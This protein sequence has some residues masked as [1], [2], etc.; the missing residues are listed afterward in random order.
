MYVAKDGIYR[1]GGIQNI[2]PSP[3]VDHARYRDDGGGNETTT[4]AAAAADDV[5]GVVIHDASAWRAES[6][7]RAAARD[8]GNC[9]RLL[10]GA[11]ILVSELASGCTSRG[12]VLRA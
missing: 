1:R 12:A 7:R 5:T 11:A 8:T 10:A 2:C 3:F 6:I 9:F 4:A